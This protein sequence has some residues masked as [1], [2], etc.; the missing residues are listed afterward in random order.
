MWKASGSQSVIDAMDSDT[1]EAMD[2]LGALMFGT[3]AIVLI[4]VICGAV[5]LLRNKKVKLGL[6]LALAGVGLQTLFTFGFILFSFAAADSSSIGDAGGT[7]ALW[8]SFLVSAVTT[9]L[10]IWSIVKSRRAAK[11]GQQANLVHFGQPAQDAVMPNYGDN[12]GGQGQQN[13]GAPQQGFQPNQPQYG[14]NQ[15]GQPQHLQ[16]PALSRTAPQP[17]RLP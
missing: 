5:F 9:G 7:F 3:A 15:F 2:D 6:F 12:Q 1:Q 17:F 8:F 10:L 16:T 13:Y 14:Q 11:M 4:L